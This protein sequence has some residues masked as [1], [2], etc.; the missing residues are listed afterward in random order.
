MDDQ[1][2][3][4]LKGA[5]EAL[6]F[7]SEKAV[8]TQQLKEAVAGSTVN[9]IKKVLKELREDYSNRDAGM[10][11]VEI[12]NGFQMLS[13]AQYAE[14]IREFYK[15]TSKEKLSRPALETL[16][17]IAY[18]QP[19]SRS[20]VEEIRGVNSDGVMTHL[21]D[22][23]LI[24]ITG[25]KE[26]PGRPFLHGTTSKFLEYFGLK[27][28][29]DLPNLEDFPVL[30]DEQIIDT[31]TAKKEMIADGRNEEEQDFE[32]D[33]DVTHL[34]EKVQAD[35]SHHDEHEE[36]IKHSR[37]ELNKAIEA[38]DDLNLD[39]DADEASDDDEGKMSRIK[40]DVEQESTVHDEE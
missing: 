34:A 1:Q 7:V 15:S 25:R 28:L 8:T 2:K 3:T 19:V 10:M 14:Y 39:E 6:L 9:D 20:D 27:S 33:A 31:H 21:L 26:I 40:V 22:K 37:E 13:S 24:K 5:I 18:K 12:A 30:D 4:H 35:F 11:I 17:I 23:G 38:V 16:A 32:S 29:D 36:A